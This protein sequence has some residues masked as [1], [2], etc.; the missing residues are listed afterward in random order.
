MPSGARPPGP[1]HLSQNLRADDQVPERPD[2]GPRRDPTALR[3]VE[4]HTFPPASRRAEGPP[5][6]SA[7]ARGAN[8]Q[9]PASPVKLERLIGATEPLDLSVFAAFV[10]FA[11]VEKPTWEDGFANRRVPD[12]IRAAVL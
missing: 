7:V 6:L 11:E 8:E 4:R 9:S 3:S 1:P 12:S 10:D 5:D 2:R